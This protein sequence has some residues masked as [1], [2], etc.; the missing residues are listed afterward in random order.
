MKISGSYCAYLAAILSV[1]VSSGPV[2]ACEVCGC[3]RNADAQCEPVHDHAAGQGG[4]AHGATDLNLFSSPT[5]S[6]NGGAAPI[7][8]A[9]IGDTQGTE[10]GGHSN[11][12]T[13]LMESVNTHNV[14]YVL[15]PGDLIGDTGSSGWNAWK[16]RTSILGTNSAGVD[17]RLMNPGNHDRGSGGTFNN[18]QNTFDWLPDSQTLG[19]QTG[20]DQV[21]YFVDHE[22]V[23]FL[24]ISTDAPGSIYNGRHVNNAPPAL[25]WMREVMKDVDNRNADADPNN[26][27]DHVFTFSHRPVTTQFESPTGGTNGE[28]WESMT[29]QDA[30]SG[31]HAATA[32]LAGHWHIYQPSRPD[33]DV[34]TVEIIS[35]TGG[36]G[37]EGQAH[38]NR[39]GYS[40]VTINGGDVTSEF[41]G[42]TN[43]GSDNWNFELLDNYTIAQTGGL[44]TG[45]LAHY[46]FESGAS[47]Q[48]SSVSA[49]SK[50]H[51]LNFNGSVGTFNDPQQG[52]VLDVTSGG[53]V[54]AKDTDDNNLAV[55]R[56]LTISL[57]AR[58]D[59]LSAGENTL[60][61]FGGAHGSSNGDLLDQESAN[62]AY[63]LSLTEAGNLQLAWQHDD[64]EWQT[65]ASDTAVA[66]PT[67]WH[68][69]EA[70]RDGDNMAVAFFVD[71]EQLG[72]V[73]GF[74]FSP[75]GAGSG[76]LYIGS[77]VGG[78]LGFDGWIDD[79]NISSSSVELTP[80]LFGDINGNGVIFGDGTGA[81]E[82]DDVT[83]FVSFWRHEGSSPADLNFDDITNIADWGILNALDPS[84]GAAVLAALRGE[85]VVP[86]PSTLVILLFGALGLRQ[87]RGLKRSHGG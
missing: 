28:W 80:P 14:D 43:Q 77:G 73:Q 45:E 24:S 62:H 31:D 75:T 11:L 16:S 26:N 3:Q 39:H 69:Y 34:D 21:D 55:L 85:N 2:L 12:L 86:E 25:D 52:Q 42:D 23:R 8:F 47:N 1:V 49:L 27:I 35:G 51:T 30:S 83:A 64:A 36:G 41:Y 79:V 59:T 82:T 4:H 84:M 87:V 57:S 48:D 40:I 32:F 6:G 17:K 13:R 78:L 81:F 60:V 20:I 5:A 44:P 50:G 58:A 71:G 37:L 33:P 15:F 76:S 70:R 61:A 53:Y 46:E 29:G 63:R 68:D 19:G 38:R 18:W 56:D 74:G 67:A 54:D 66:D 72:L 9:V 7:K 10:N 65:I 22:N